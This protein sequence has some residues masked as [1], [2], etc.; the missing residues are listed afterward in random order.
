MRRYARR[1]DRRNNRTVRTARTKKK[2]VV[3]T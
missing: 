1:H 2:M 3:V